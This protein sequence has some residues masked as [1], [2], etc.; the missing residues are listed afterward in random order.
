M[1]RNGNFHF[2]HGLYAYY[3]LMIVFMITNVSIAYMTWGVRTHVPPSGSAHEMTFES[4][5]KIKYLKHLS[6]LCT[7]NVAIVLYG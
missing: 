4:K 7:L 6:I 1:A 5:V 2:F 3:D